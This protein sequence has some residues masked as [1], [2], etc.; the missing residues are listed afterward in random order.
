MNTWAVARTGPNR[1]STAS[2]NAVTLF[3]AS[4]MTS[5]LH[6]ARLALTDVVLADDG[7]TPS[8]HSRTKRP[9]P[10]A[11][12]FHTGSTCLSS[13]AA[14]TGR[15]GFWVCFDFTPRRIA[16]I[17]DGVLTFLWKSHGKVLEC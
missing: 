7:F 4:F 5:S 15:R 2:A 17:S 12:A 1:T 10:A 16:R 11:K 14:A 6:E 3:E 8:P 9:G 13:P